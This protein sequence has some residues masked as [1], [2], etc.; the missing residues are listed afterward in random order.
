[1]SAGPPLVV[2]RGGGDLATGAAA[3]LHRAGI[4]II[5]TELLRPL[6]LRRTVALAEAVFSGE[7][8]VEDLL[9]RRAGSPALA[10]ALA[11]QGILPVL[12][13]PE[14]DCLSELRPVALVD[15]RMR[16]QPNELGLAAAPLVIGLGPGFVASADCHAVV[17]TRRGHRLGRVLWQGPAEADTRL[18]EAVGG[19]AARR[20]LRAPVDG[21]VEG[22]VEIGDL[23][24]EGQVVIRMAGAEVRA[25]FD[26]VLRGLVHPGV[27]VP[28]GTKIGDVD[29]RG[30]PAYCWEISDK[31]LAVGGGVLEA[32][33][34]QRDLRRRLGE[35]SGAAG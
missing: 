5:I 6:V 8:Q 1:M 20:V 18:P 10:R 4:A 2:I 16:K 27:E 25:P 11:L 17:E 19:Q 14:C 29:P 21:L 34:M 22:L 7:T 33:L 28:A 3:R 32:L 24:K 23:V 30:V 35:R 9:G 31:S 15:A 13:D 26:G 12:I